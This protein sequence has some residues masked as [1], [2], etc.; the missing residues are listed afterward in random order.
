MVNEA[1]LETMR[2]AITAAV[3]GT[4][5]GERG[6][7][8]STAITTLY[9]ALNDAWK[10]AAKWRQIGGTGPRSPRY[11]TFRTLGDT[12]A[13][14]LVPMPPG[15]DGYRVVETADGDFLFSV[16]ARQLREKLT[17]APDGARVAITLCESPA[18]KS[19]VFDVVVDGVPR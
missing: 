17:G 11:F 9:A 18:G 12:V 3:R 14:V 4:T 19:K 13:G 8:S 16:A 7:V 10:G 6:L 15:M 2:K 1:L 5:S